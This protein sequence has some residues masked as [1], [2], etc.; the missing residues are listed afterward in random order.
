MLTNLLTI[1]SAN[2][3]LYMD[4]YSLFVCTIILLCMI[5]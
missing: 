5:C 1:N 4:T 3:I 2:L